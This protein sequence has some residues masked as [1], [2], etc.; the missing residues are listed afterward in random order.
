MAGKP[1]KRPS[2]MPSR[3]FNNGGKAYCRHVLS[4]HALHASKKVPICRCL[5]PCLL[6]AIGTPLFL[7]AVRVFLSTT[8]TVESAGFLSY[9]LN[10]HSGPKTE[11][12]SL[13]PK[14]QTAAV[15]R[16][17]E[18]LS[19]GQGGASPVLASAKSGAGFRLWP[20]FPVREMSAAVSLSSSAQSGAS[21]VC[22]RRPKHAEDAGFG[23]YFP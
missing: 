14:A 2:W 20:L 6:S 16:L 18:P 11:Q 23:R 12:G 17:W 5:L 19:D 3:H 22:G 9:C 15:F 10:K 1:W 13:W 8:L 4:C 21:A 7:S